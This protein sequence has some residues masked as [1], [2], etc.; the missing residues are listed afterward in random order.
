MT[1][2]TC[3]SPAAGRLEASD[4]SAQAAS[5]DE[6]AQAVA[7]FMRGKRTLAVTGAGISTDSGIPDYRG[8][9]TTPRKPVD[10]DQFVTDPVWYRWVWARN[11]ATWQL[12]EPL[13]PTPGHRALARLEAAG[14]VTGVATQNV[15]RLHSRAGQATAWELHGAYD[16]VVC[17][18]CDRRTTR[19]ALDSRLTALNPD[20]P[21]ERDPQ[22]IEITPETDRAAAESCTFETVMCQSC[23]GLLKPDIVFFGESLPPAMEE[24]MGVARHSDVVLV[25]GTSLAVL[26]GLWV[27][28]QA[29]ACGARL[30]VI[31][32]SPTAVDGAADIR[33]EGGTSEVLDAVA[34]HLLG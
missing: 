31:N 24:A 27:V 13:E 15:D 22:R 2:P 28:H 9:G 29:M 25:A 33:V 17:L 26:T 6:A 5:V 11:H 3:G 32:R 16:R 10:Y 18:G 23:G 7:E 1:A 14:L 21:R 34:H 20:Y 4:A 19:A 8:I 30:I 12:L